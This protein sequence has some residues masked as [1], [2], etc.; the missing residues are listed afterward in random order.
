MSDSGRVPVPGASLHYEVEGTGPAVVLAHGLSLDT[1]MWDD[2]VPALR[3]IA[4]VVRYDSRGHGQSSDPDPDVAFRHA[5]DLWA[6]VDHLGVDS[7]V[8]VGL[9]MGGRIVVD[10]AVTAPER[11]RAL[12]TLDAVLDGVDWDADALDSII[13]AGQTARDDLEAGRRLWLA[14]PFFVPA[15]RDPK[16]AARLDEIVGDWRGYPWTVPDPGVAIDPPAIEVLDRI[17]APTTVVVGELDVRCFRAMAA[18]LATDIPEAQLVTVP[19]AGHM[20]N[21][22]A[23]DTVNALLREVVASV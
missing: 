2:Q 15:R 3:D 9:S 14:H 4:T 19:D 17:T 1:R 10:A 5:D 11:V 22:E 23:P 7:A 12:V 21:M 8:L 13:A 18:V 16:V 6:V 20:V